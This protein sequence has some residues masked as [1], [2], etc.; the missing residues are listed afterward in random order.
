M[1]TKL[2][3]YLV[4]WFVR[5]LSW[6]YRFEFQG[7]ENKEA[8]KKLSPLGA[9][10]Y[11]VWHQNLL[12]T[13]LANTGTAHVCIVSPSKDGELVATTLNL[14]GHQCARGSSSRGGKKAMDEMIRLISEGYP[15][16]ITVDGP[17]G[18][19]KVPKK[20]VFEI[21][22]ATGVPILPVCSWPENFWCFEKSWDQFRLPKPFSKIIVYFGEPM[23]VDK[24][25]QAS[26][27]PRLSEELT[28]I[29]HKTE[30]AAMRELQEN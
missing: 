15:G 25:S 23:L 4:H 14:L 24:S 16:A 1:K 8:A 9:Y 12:A 27:L 2:L 6:S 29:M 11:S 5:L 28:A 30:L 7:V 18:P 20:G 26:D 17:R 13:I 21:A 10:V 3:A 19:A 22:K